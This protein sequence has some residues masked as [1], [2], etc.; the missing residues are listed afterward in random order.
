MDIEI[1]TEKITSGFYPGQIL[2]VVNET[3]LEN[4]LLAKGELIRF[5]EDDQVNLLPNSI[6]L[7]I[8]CETLDE[9]F[10]FI[11]SSTDVKP[12]NSLNSMRKTRFYWDIEGNYGFG[13]GWECVTAAATLKEARQHL[14]EYRE[15][16]PSGS[17]RL[18]KRIERYPDIDFPELA[19]NT[20]A[21]NN[22]PLFD[23]LREHKFSYEW[24]GK[25]HPANGL[26]KADVID[27][28]NRLN[29]QEIADLIADGIITRK[30]AKNDTE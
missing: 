1:T 6:E 13:D 2:R 23:W 29:I 12:E 14:R 19:A 5:I 27:G 28:I 26:S 20:F 18:K 22:E 30:G 16:E 24:D 3:A 4:E 15:N 9:T 17:Y 10:S 8:F 21:G 11:I 25:R 7:L